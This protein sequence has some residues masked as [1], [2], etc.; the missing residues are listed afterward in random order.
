MQ[1]RRSSVGRHGGGGA[2]GS[3]FGAHPHSRTFFF[4]ASYFVGVHSVM[5]RTLV[6]VVVVIVA[7]VVVV[8]VVVLE[9]DVVAV[10]VVVVVNVVG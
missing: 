10:V 1:P 2:D 5:V 7:V 8:V 3:S 9:L 4:S 6:V